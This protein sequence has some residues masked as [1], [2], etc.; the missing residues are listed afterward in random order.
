MASSLL[1]GVSAYAYGE[2][3]KHIKNIYQFV[4]YGSSLLTLFTDRLSTQTAYLNVPHVVQ[5]IVPQLFLPVASEHSPDDLVPISH[6]VS[7]EHDIF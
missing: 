1:G 4:C 6:M 5:R 7:F 3:G 2:A